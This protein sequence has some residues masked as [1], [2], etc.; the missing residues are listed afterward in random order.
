MSLIHGV[1]RLKQDKVLASVSKRKEKVYF[2]SK[3]LH[4][5]DMKNL[6]MDLSNCFGIKR[7]DLTIDFSEKNVAIIYAPNGTMKSSLA[8]TFKCIRTGKP[9]EERRFQR[10]S[11]CVVSDESGE[12]IN[13]GM[14]MVINPFDKKTF[15]GQGLLMANERMRDDYATIYKNIGA[16]KKKL[17]EN[18]KTILGYGTRSVFDVR[19]TML[20]DWEVDEDK[21]YDCLETIVSCI[22]KDEF[23]LPLSNE[24]LKYEELFNTKVVSN[25][26]TE[27]VVNLLEDY[28]NKYNEIISSN[29]WKITSI[30]RKIRNLLR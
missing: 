23:A 5:G 16:Q 22:G 21:E 26:L 4:V 15:D 25:V 8:E 30:F 18:I 29:S 13:P 7:M 3:S 17:Y 24:E 28:E 20:I 12:S 2:T 19:T 27:E 6:R 10:V 11:N 9:I 1:G 14:V